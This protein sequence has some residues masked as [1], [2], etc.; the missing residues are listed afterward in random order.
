MAKPLSHSAQSDLISDFKNAVASRLKS[1]NH[2]DKQ[3]GDVT[4]EKAEQYR[5][6][7]QQAQGEHQYRT[8]EL[9]QHF[10]SQCQQIS[11]DFDAQIAAVQQEYDA[12]KAETDRNVA[13]E[14]SEA[15]EKMQESEWMVKSM[16]DDQ[17]DD[18]PKLKFD[19]FK[20]SLEKG[21]EQF[22]SDK[23]I[24][25]QLKEKATAIVGNWGIRPTEDVA[26]SSELKA[27]TLQEA[28]DLFRENFEAVEE[29]LSQ[30]QKSLMPKLVAGW[31]IIIVFVLIAA[32][33]S[34]LILFV[35][36][37]AWFGLNM[38]NGDDNWLIY[39]IGIGSGA[40]LL[41]SAF[42]YFAVMGKAKS[43]FYHLQKSFVNSQY[44][45]RLW[46]RNGKADLER[47]KKE[48]VRVYKEIEKQRQAALQKVE[49]QHAARIK[50]IEQSHS[51]IL[52]KFEQTYKPKIANLEE[53]RQAEINKAGEVY[54]HQLHEMTGHFKEQYGDVE[55]QQQDYVQSQ[56][57]AE[58]QT[59]DGMMT[60]WKESLTSL[61]DRIHHMQDVS[62]RETPAWSEMIDPSWELPRKIP[63]AIRLGDM[64]FE[65]SDIDDAIPMDGNMVP[66][67]TDYKVPLV[68]PF[69]NY[70]SMMIK[71]N[72]ESREKCSEMMQSAMLRL[73]ATLPAGKVRFTI[74]DPMGLGE[75]YSSFMHLAD[76]DELMINNRIWT[77]SGQ[78]D[79]RLSE[80]TE[81]ME[82]VFQAY[83]RNEYETI[84]DYNHHAGEVA[85]PYRILVVA[86]FP[87]NFNDTASKRLISIASSGPRCGVYTLIS[88][89]TKQ[90]LPHGFDIEELEKCSTTFEWEG[91]K[92]YLS[93]P[94]LKN[95]DLDFIPPPEP[96]LFGQIVRRI[97]ELSKDARRVE[98][99]FE[100][101]VPPK[102]EIWK[103]NSQSGLSVPLGRAGA[104][105]LQHMNL[106][107][108]TSQHV[109]I[110]GK[111]GSGKSTFLH[112]LI[113][114]LAL[115]YSPDQV[116]LFLIDFKKGVEFKTY[117]AH[118]LPHAKVIAIESDREFGVSV[119][120][121]LDEMLKER[122][123]LFR[124][125]NVQDLAGFRKARPD[126]KMPRVMLI[127][128]EFQEFF[129]EDD[130]L[131]QNATLLLDRLVR[132]GRAFGIHVLLGSQ[133]LGG[134]Y[135][136]ARSTLG[137]VA[138]RIAL[139]CSESD[140]H[141]ILSEENTAA[142][143]LTRPGEAIYNDANGLLEGNHPF[144]IA[145][146]GDST[147]DKYLGIIA[148]RVRQEG[149]H[150]E[151]PIVFEGNIASDAARN[152]VLTEIVQSR[153]KHRE[154][155]F[156]RLYK[157]WLGEAVA[158]TEPAFCEFRRQS[159][160]H[161]L[162]VGAKADSARGI[163]ATGLISLSAQ[164][165]T[166]WPPESFATTS[167]ITEDDASSDE[168]DSFG[169]FPA[170]P[171][172]PSS[173]ESSD[174]SANELG[175]DDPGLPSLSD[176]EAE[177]SS[178]SS[179]DDS[180]VPDMFRKPVSSSSPF[181]DSS[182][183]P[184]GMSSSPEPKSPEDPT[185]PAAT[186]YVLDGDLDEEPEMTHWEE[187]LPAIPH[188]VKLGGI[189]KS[190]EFLEEAAQHVAWRY[191]TDATDKQP[192]IFIVIYHLGRFR[193]LR[194]TDDD[195]GFNSS[196][197]S[198][199][200]TGADH[201]QKIIKEG[202]AVGVHLLIWCDSYS[203]VTRW[204]SSQLLREM[205]TRVAFDMN[206][207]DSSNFI[208]SPVAS[209]LG[210]HRAFF[211]QED[212]GRLD[213]FRPYGFPTVAWINWVGS[214]LDPSR[215][216]IAELPIEEEADP[217]SILAAEER[218]KEEEA[219]EAA[220]EEQKKLQA[221]EDAETEQNQDE[222]EVE[223]V[224]EKEPV[225]EQVDDESDSSPSKSK[226]ETTDD[227][228]DF[229]LSDD[230]DLWSIT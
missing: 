186:F 144:Q 85:E 90:K 151:P 167:S 27:N 173:A 97:G 59:R 1:E 39:S 113:T 61:D 79:A 12:R 129:V 218:R 95:L 57:E 221:R 31:K 120:E 110:A 223:T 222:P 75:D 18:S 80:L 63:H 102:G 131:A 69:P 140:A 210:T 71:T 84:E 195:F 48:Y 58:H 141:L 125:H 145:W 184:F 17:S 128:D 185:S 29:A 172:G 93:Y 101:V 158:I 13:A 23:E 177:L 225:V 67:Q 143:L 191:K 198:S 10:E 127:V 190:D 159:G 212:Q 133:T 14:R 51:E 53:T 115:Y 196:R 118:R 175:S 49:R 38:T 19:Q 28:R 82:N 228:G 165:P 135:S 87:Y 138:V 112:I 206:A 25:S 26:P 41:V 86:N 193:E 64:N 157:M 56:Q 136:L 209:R 35:V 211:Y 45:Q 40:S 70:T 170:F 54:Q 73:L 107:K 106:G 105:K 189:R 4:M 22:K 96:Q 180:G 155:K 207:T 21:Q 178:D 121:R 15:Q 60:N 142:R 169:S 16:F 147:R 68:L 104:T 46:V 116:Q 194:K 182:S 205:E 213:K 154:T 55:K 179:S 134:A 123:D 99:S 65:M 124:D 156:P 100:R 166:T 83:L 217:P 122:G 117:A 33:I 176:L 174:E 202:P 8:E 163:L 132:Q 78:I 37:P 152:E 3:F 200:V 94:Q 30:L 114:N 66:E 160:N 47:E 119:L 91:G 98:V 214:Y 89:D 215:E 6:S 81:H 2:L 76:Y 162:M 164:L 227:D 43:R 161:L 109:L 32:A 92:Y 11:A 230:L 72:T 20:S 188:Q 146:L 5:Q 220:A 168:K 103:N 42:F 208:D 137:Q 150:F 50:E 88:V 36:N 126:V 197:G 77:E 201:L 171:G 181:G 226:S 187:I 148:N 62:N 139:Q 153:P 74:I 203:N 149:L 192:P 7:L 219:A 229:D 44:A 9:K 24:L 111:T 183:N 108:G 204:M 52:N 34:G 130:N 199:V 224:A 216:P